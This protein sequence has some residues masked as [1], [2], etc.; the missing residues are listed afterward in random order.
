MRSFRMQLPCS[1]LPL[2]ADVVLAGAELASAR[3]RFTV[4]LKVEGVRGAC[5]SPLRATGRN[6]PRVALQ[7]SVTFPARADPRQLFW[8]LAFWQV[9]RGILLVPAWM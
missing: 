1:V 2:L 8:L 7:A 4:T 9:L 6:A 5:I 3:A